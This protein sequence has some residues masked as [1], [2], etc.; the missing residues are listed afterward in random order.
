[1]IEPD[2]ADSPPRLLVGRTAVVTGAA[3]GIGLSVARR[4]AENGAQVAL[5]DLNLTGV[6]AA[7][8]AI[9]DGTGARTLPVGVDVSDPE[10]VSR[11]ADV[12]EQ[13]LG[14]CD[15]VVA[16]AGVLVLKPALDLT[17]P[18]FRRVLDINLVGAF[19]TAREFGQRLVDSGQPGQILF[20]SSLFGL[21]G[22]P[23]NSAY[24]ASKFG[25]IGLAQSM[26]AEL[27]P[28][29]IRVNSVC[30]GQIESDMLEELFRERALESGAS[31]A[32][33][34]DRLAS[35]VPLG[36]LGRVDEVADTFVYLASSLS[37]YVTG[38]HIVVDGAWSLR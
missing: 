3:R 23:S 35:S 16:N 21:R 18:E 8:D 17:T 14:V 28:S 15:I 24:S 4:F 34:R 13:D 11:A 29:G 2:P 12:I 20:S 27:A 36:R 38:Q 10:S 6:T 22:G 1:M 32:D 37:A 25:L 31:P 33:E 7:A 19:T 5:V 30:P 26:A 9:R